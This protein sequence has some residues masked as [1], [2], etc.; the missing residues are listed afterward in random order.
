MT[1]PCALLLL[2]TCPDA[3]S[4]E[5][6]SRTLVSE[7]LAACVGQLPGLLSTYRWQGNI[8]QARE[9]QL[10]IKASIRHKEALMDRIMALHPYEV[11]ELLILNVDDGLPAYLHWLDETS[12]THEAD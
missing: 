2:T 8:E 12:D 7:G 3:D 11:P 4:A 5:R 1:T 9:Y 6:I 10:L